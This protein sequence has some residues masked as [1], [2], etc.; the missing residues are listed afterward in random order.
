MGKFVEAGL[1]FAERQ[2][3]VNHEEELS[4]AFSFFDEGKRQLTQ[5]KVELLVRGS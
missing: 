3:S 5:T 2:A 1:S 4:K